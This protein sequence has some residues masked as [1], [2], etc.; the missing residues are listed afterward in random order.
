VEGEKLAVSQGGEA[1]ER[2][3]NRRGAV[4]VVVVAGRFLV[5]RRSNN[6]AAPGAIC[7]PGGA[8][9]PGES[10]TEAMVREVQEELGVVAVPQ[11]RLWQNVTNWGVEIAWWQ[12]ALENREALRPNPE[13]V[14]A[15][16]WYATDELRRCRA[17]L[18]SN[19]EFLQAM[20]R[21]EFSLD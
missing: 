8:I 15:V 21:G 2:G 10:E 11:K 4:A 18:A 12:A 19:H 20:D 3:T 6:V 1:G 14:A 9:E 5:I 7:F 17:L 13:E 16:Y